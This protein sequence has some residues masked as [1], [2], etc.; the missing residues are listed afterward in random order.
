M[1]NEIK[2]KEEYEKY[3]RDH[4]K[5]LDTQ[6]VKIGDVVKVLVGQFAGETGIVVGII[7]CDKSDYTD[8]YY[9]IA[10]NCEVPEKY[11]CR[12]TL[13]TPNN[14]AGGFSAHDFEVIGN[15]AP[16]QPSSEIKVGDKVRVRED[17]PKMY[18]R[19]RMYALITHD[20]KV[21]AVE[22]DNAVI[23]LGG[24]CFPIPTKYLVKVDAEVKE[25]KFK[26]GD[27]VRYIG[28]VHEHKGEIFVI[29]GDIFFNDYYKQWQASSI[30]T[31]PTGVWSICNVPLS[32]LEPDTAPAAPKIKV[33]DRVRNI[34]SGL[35]GVVDKIVYGN[36]AWVNGVDGKR[37]HW[38]SDE[39][40]LVEPT[41]QTEAEKKPYDGLSEETANEISDML[42]VYVKVLSGIAD[43]FDW[44]R[45]AAD[46]A[47]EVALKAA[48]KFND[49]EQAAEYAVKVAKAVVEWLKRK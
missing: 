3:A 48:N 26:K 5:E 30:K 41:E 12:K 31:I 24:D 32:D 15:R 1:S 29:D 18:A 45:Y 28:D 4:R 39:L 37:Y 9:E 21:E 42:E 46:L 6:E 23:S 10:L 38:K 25:A 14:V 27:R 17:A 11:K 43:S 44:Q 7:A 47:K 49:P 33:G 36:I 2:E 34:E 16:K 19:G 20:C 8:P 35:I 40:E 22:D 13:I